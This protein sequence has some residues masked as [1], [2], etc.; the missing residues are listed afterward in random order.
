MN[1]ATDDPRFARSLAVVLGHEG[2]FVRHP[3]DPGG[4][5]NFGITQ[6]TL[7][8]ARGGRADA[9]DVRRLTKDEAAV[10]YRCFYW[11][12]MKASEMPPGVALALFDFAV[13][14]GVP[15][16]VRQ[17]QSILGVEVDGIV[18]PQTLAAISRADPDDL[19][20]RLTRARLGFL[21]RLA[22]WSVFGRGWRRRVLAVEQ[23]ALRLGL[24]PSL[25]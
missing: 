22:T 18:G 4:A 1:D 9:D 5:T 10:I 2:G 21:A 12:A 17:L 3:F 6:R 16:A 24:S 25:S 15:R 11:D 13:N 20:R 14:S 23:D 7:A 19:V 8:R